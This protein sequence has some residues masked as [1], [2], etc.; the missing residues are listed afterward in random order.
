MK[1]Q[2]FPS[3]SLTF[4]WEWLEAEREIVIINVHCTAS[5]W[6]ISQVET[7]ANRQT[8]IQTGKAG[9]G[10]QREATYELVGECPE[11]IRQEKVQEEA[12]G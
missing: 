7:S 2:A 1:A 12:R 6:I 3:Q 5:C 4:Y 8:Q 11:D 10:F 9:E